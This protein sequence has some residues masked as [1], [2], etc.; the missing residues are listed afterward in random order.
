MQLPSKS[1]YLIFVWSACL[2]A[3]TTLVDHRNHSIPGGKWRD[4]CE[5][6]WETSSQVVL[7]VRFKCGDRVSLKVYGL[8]LKSNLLLR[9][10]LVF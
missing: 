9:Q 10:C 7:K 1:F 8:L 5:E 3:I 6:E 2:D 4:L